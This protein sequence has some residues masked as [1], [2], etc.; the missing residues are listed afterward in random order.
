MKSMLPALLAFSAPILL[1]LPAAGEAPE[2]EAI[3]LLGKELI[4]PTAP[5]AAAAPQ[6]EAIDALKRRLAAREN[7]AE[8][9]IWLGRRVAYLGRYR[10]SIEIFGRGASLHP[11]D[12]RFLRHRGHRHLTLRDIPA[13][14][15]DFERGLALSAGRPDEVEPDGLPNLFNR[16]TSTLKTNLWY[17]LGLA[18][19]LET[20]FR[21]AAEAFTACVALADNPDMWVGGTYWRVLSLFRDDRAAEAR[22]ILA[23]LPAKL[24]LVEN[25]EYF[26]L[27]EL[28]AGRV[29]LEDFGAGGLPATL[30]YGLGAF[31]LIEGRA[32][33][34]REV[35]AK[36]AEGGA[37]AAFGHL[38]AEAEL[39][40]CAGR[41]PASP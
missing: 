3:S 20:D 35:F 11:E 38:A 24:E 23:A 1:A 34:A 33:Q 36:V 19:Y 4:R 18:R 7:D 40:G 8:A 30:S 17:H 12:A 29:K 15:A 39:C 28:F 6:L 27:L 22:A 37:W 26:R 31:H 2:V 41:R 32:D 13:A 10:E 25:Q 5:A 9:L 14:I 21:R 16:P